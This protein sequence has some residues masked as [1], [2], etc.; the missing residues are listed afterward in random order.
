M[1]WIVFVG[2]S[3]P[4]SSV[5]PTSSSS[6]LVRMRIP[7]EELPFPEAGLPQ[8][9]HSSPASSHNPSPFPSL[10]STPPESR[11]PPKGSPLNPHTSLNLA[12]SLT[13]DRPTGNNVPSPSLGLDRPPSPS[14]GPDKADLAD[15]HAQLVQ[16]V[17]QVAETTPPEAL[18]K[19]ERQHRTSRSSSIDIPNI[20]RIGSV[21]GALSK[22][23]SMARQTK[24][25]KGFFSSLSSTTSHDLGAG[26]PQP[27]LY[28]NSDVQHLPSS[29]TPTATPTTALSPAS[30]VEQGEFATMASPL[31]DHSEWLSSTS[32]PHTS[33]LT[34]PPPLYIPHPDTLAFSGATSQAL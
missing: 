10:P 34:S 4:K 8:S 24:V 12:A 17:Q 3:L 16:Q 32:P 13:N 2:S 18:E 9:V 5:S 22:V 6:S 14:L 23:K 7:E 28:R 31:S 1:C 21:S 20:P 11:T 26:P 19:Q 15:S 27:T 29:V 33:P 30:S 25:V